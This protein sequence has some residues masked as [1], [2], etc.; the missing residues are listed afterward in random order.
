[1][2]GVHTL[3]MC[4][5]HGV[6]TPLLDRLS[7]QGQLVKHDFLP[8]GL[9]APVEQ[10]F[11]DLACPVGR[12]LHRG[13]LIVHALIQSRN[14]GRR[15]NRH[16]FFITPTSGIH[17]D[18]LALNV[19]RVPDRSGRQTACIPHPGMLSVMACLRLILSELLPRHLSWPRLTPVPL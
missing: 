13:R 10:V 19:G 15:L 11:E 6:A 8:V 12:A 3:I 14:I 7:R 18:G 4:V 1:M 16:M 17:L 9:L 5:V 2:D